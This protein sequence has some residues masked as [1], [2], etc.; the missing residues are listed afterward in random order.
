VNEGDDGGDVSAEASA[1][2]RPQLA[3]AEPR[4]GP[5]P[6][7]R[8]SNATSRSLTDP[9]A[10]L[11]GKPG[12]R[13]HLVHRGQV[14]VDPRAR[15]VIACLGADGHE[16]DALAPIT[17]RARFAC[18]ELKSVG[19]DQGFAAE[20]VWGAISD[21][22]IRAFVP[23]Q[24]T[25]L[26]RDGGEPKTDAQRAALAARERCKTAAGVWSHSQRMADAE[27]VVGELK[28]R[29]GLDRSRCRGTPVFHVQ[30]LLAAPR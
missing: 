4:S 28:Q 19:A 12:Q 25:M 22:G 29:H 11:R 30:L 21:R 10:R 24:R 3:L 5:A 20:R 15:C 14:A 16:G 2:D 7:R 9:D 27:G 8:S 23:P 13:P 6:E 26:P 18:A 17:D 1:D